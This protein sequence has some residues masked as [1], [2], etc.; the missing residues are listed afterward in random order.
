MTTLKKPTPVSITGLRHILSNQKTTFQDMLFDQIDNS[1]EATTVFDN[2]NS[3]PISL[4]FIN[5]KGNCSRSGYINDAGII[6]SG[7]N[8]KNENE[9]VRAMSYGGTSVAIKG[10][11]HTN[12]DVGCFGHGNNVWKFT[13]HGVQ[14]F[15]K[16]KGADKIMH[17]YYKDG[18]LECGLRDF[19]DYNHPKAQWAL[20]MHNEYHAGKNSPAHKKV[21]EIDQSNFKESHFT[22][23]YLQDI[24]AG[25]GFDQNKPS[26]FKKKFH[27]GKITNCYSKMDK[28]HINIPGGGGYQIVSK[29]PLKWNEKEIEQVLDE[30]R[31]LKGGQISVRASWDPR[32]TDV[33][34]YFYM[35]SRL[36]QARHL[37]GI[38][39]GSM[40]KKYGNF[41]KSELRGLKL[42]FDFKQDLKSDFG[43]D[44]VKSSIQLENSV[45]EWVR[46]EFRE[47]YDKVKALN[48]KESKARTTE[49]TKEISKKLTKQLRKLDKRKDISNL[50]DGEVQITAKPKTKGK[51][52]GSKKGSKNTPPKNKPTKNKKF[53]G[54][55]VEAVI[56]T[57]RDKLLWD[58]DNSPEKIIIHI[59]EDDPYYKKKYQKLNTDGKKLD[60]FECLMEVCHTALKVALLEEKGMIEPE[61]VLFHRQLDTKLKATLV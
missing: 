44:P 32:S 3:I 49:Q 53:L 24:N 22:I 25:E 1:I 59:N 13:D 48:N 17:L 19:Y 51:N 61:A 42:D 16:A 55:E 39:Y 4:A 12:D 57:M 58:Y 28:V 6:D 7:D 8:F 56:D 43:V 45:L 40:P 27:T 11:H 26:G 21:K 41:K 30:T 2:G 23:T 47:L 9:V 52:K 36:I 54:R 46:T 35:N 34:G 60:A 14:Y 20:Q 38:I 33:M 5:K 37:D 31:S 15:G 29:D 50:V 18:D 10:T